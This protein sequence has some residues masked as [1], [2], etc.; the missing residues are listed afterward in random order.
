MT[1]ASLTAKRADPDRRGFLIAGVF[2]VWVANIYMAI[3]GRLRLGLRKERDDI[4]AEE[5]IFAHS[6]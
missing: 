5:S 3:F 6:K 1:S 2:L 4:T